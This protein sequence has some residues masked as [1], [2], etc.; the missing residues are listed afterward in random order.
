MKPL[1]KRA[2]RRKRGSTTAF[3][4]LGMIPMI[5]IMALGFEIGNVAV[6]Y[7]RLQNYVDSKAVAA[8]KEEFGSLAQDVE[9]HRFVDGAGPPGAPAVDAQPEKGHWDFD[10]F[11]AAQLGLPSLPPFIRTD[12]LSLQPGR[13]PAYRVGVDPFEV[14]LL[15]GPL[16]NVPSV[17]IRAEAVA[18][19]PR[20]EVVIVQDV[21]GSMC[22]PVDFGPCGPGAAA[23]T[24]LAQA[25]QANLTL[26]G[27]MN[28]QGV[29]GDRIGVVDF[30]NGIV[31]TLPLTALSGGV[32]NVTSFI[33]N[34]VSNAGG[35]AIAGGLQAGVNLFNAVGPDPEVERILIL[36]GD[37]I[38]G[39][40][41]ASLTATAN[42]QANFGI[43]TYSIF[44]CPDN[45]CPNGAAYLGTP[46]PQ[47]N[48]TFTNAPN[49]PVLTQLLNDIV[50]GVP[51]KLVQ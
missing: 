44:F 37:G 11:N 16:F 18:F 22:Q 38:D 31:R 13:V 2:A 48:G 8:L 50:T 26:V 49:G 25:V 29:P 7:R 32:G 43:H 40:R 23:N 39:N 10:A 15:F 34:T 33:T 36:I 19:A 9:F 5:G 51:M 24:R 46:L 21:S 35:T 41:G 20:R 47:G 17:Q 3:F 30:D 14:P 45:N 1:E 6:E 42:A 12:S 4:S 28:G 27:Q